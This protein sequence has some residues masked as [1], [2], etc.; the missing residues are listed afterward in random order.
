M[1]DN[2]KKTGKYSPSKRT[3]QN[4]TKLRHIM[5]KFIEGSLTNKKLLRKATEARQYFNTN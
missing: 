2:P 4:T 3:L 1:E 5:F